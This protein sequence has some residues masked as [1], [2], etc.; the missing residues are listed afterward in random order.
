M[1]HKPNEFL[2]INH[3]ALLQQFF[4]QIKIDDIDV[5]EHDGHIIAADDYG[6]Q[7]ED[8]R[9]YDFALNECLA[10][11]KNGDLKDGFASVSNDLSTALKI[12][13]AAY[14]VTIRI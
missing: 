14:G 9:V 4:R 1:N 3:C 5:Y 8:A 2:L 10:W 12:H 11:N 13:A 7:W 6:N